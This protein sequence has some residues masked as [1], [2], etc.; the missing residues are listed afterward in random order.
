MNLLFIVLTSIYVNK[1][2]HSFA[3][4]YNSEKKG[5]FLN[6]IRHNM[7]I[8]WNRKS[9]NFIYFVGKDLFQTIRKY[10]F[11]SIPSSLPSIL[12]L[13]LLLCATILQLDIFVLC[14]CSIRNGYLDEV[15]SVFLLC[16]I[17]FQRWPK[18]ISKSLSKLNNGL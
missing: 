4:Q 14:L 17:I 15:I 6:G 5:M 8:D 3:Q 13:L 1:Y 10:S 2:H 12:L 11:F 9:D 16:N 7:S 18:T